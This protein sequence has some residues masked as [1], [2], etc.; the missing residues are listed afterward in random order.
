MASDGS[1]FD[2]K[3]TGRKPGGRNSTRTLPADMKWVLDHL[4]EDPE[5][6]GLETPG[7]SQATRA[8]WV[9]AW[10]NKDKFMSRV[11]SIRLQKAEESVVE[12]TRDACIDLVDQMLASFAKEKA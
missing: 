2:G 6:S 7:K 8:M 1:Q 10:G 9:W 5:T 4:H 11:M 12:D 3:R